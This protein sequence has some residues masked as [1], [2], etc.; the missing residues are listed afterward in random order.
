MNALP[1]HMT[2]NGIITASS[3]EQNGKL[4]RAAQAQAQSRTVQIHKNMS[5]D[6]PSAEAPHDGQEH[7]D[8]NGSEDMDALSRAIVV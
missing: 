4:G 1:L 3:L 2:G 8:Q 7:A 6:R 5:A